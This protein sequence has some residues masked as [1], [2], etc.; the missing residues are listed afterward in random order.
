[1]DVVKV[2]VLWDRRCNLNCSYCAM[3]DGRANSFPLERWLDGFSQAR[4]FGNGFCAFYGAEPLKSFENLPA[5]IEHC[6]NIGTKTTVITSGVVPDFHRK[7]DILYDHGLRSLTMSHDLLDEGL[8]TSSQVKS[9]NVFAGLDHFRRYGRK[10]R[11]VA[12]VT[13]LTRSNFQYLVPSIKRLSG[14]GIWQFFD[15]IHSDRGAPGTKCRD[16]E[17][18]DD[19][20]FRAE[21]AQPLMKVLQEVELL[22]EQ[23]YLVH[24]GGPYF[25]EL[26]RS[27]SGRL[28]TDFSWHCAKESE[29]PAWLTVDCDGQ[30]GVCDDFRARNIPA[31]YFDGLTEN[32]ETFVAEQRKASLADCVGCCWGTHIGATAIKRGL[33]TFESYVHI[34]EGK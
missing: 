24:S 28:V 32:W 30:L 15:L 10:V 5:V 12:L 11:D 8:D 33:E 20:L 18:M 25:M 16:Y 17:G 31:V 34:E 26:L 4:V 22:R 1:M 29:F 19:L 13:T 6:E 2:E 23:G 21:D 14:L 3:V 9:Q 27:T 7:L